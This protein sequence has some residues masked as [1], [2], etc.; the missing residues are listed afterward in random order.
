MRRRRFKIAVFVLLSVTVVP[1]AAEEAF[2]SWPMP[3]AQAVG[4]AAHVSGRVGRALDLRLL[5]TERAYNYKLSAT[6]MTPNAVRASARLI[7][8]AE[9]LSNEATLALVARA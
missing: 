4:D 1:T 8:L 9:R 5:K 7:Q 2:L 6:W 3:I